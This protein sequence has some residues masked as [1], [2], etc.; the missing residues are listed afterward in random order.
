MCSSLSKY[1]SSLCHRRYVYYLLCLSSLC[2]FSLLLVV[3]ML[4]V[5]MFVV[6]MFVVFTLVV[7]H[8]VRISSTVFFR[9]TLA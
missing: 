4:T 8:Y 1:S 6:A 7:F 5:A 9:P 2:S 3:F